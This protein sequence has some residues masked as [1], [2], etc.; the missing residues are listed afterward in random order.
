VATKN[1]DNTMRTTAVA[2][3]P[4]AIDGGSMKFE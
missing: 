2:V 1:V 4:D 3:T